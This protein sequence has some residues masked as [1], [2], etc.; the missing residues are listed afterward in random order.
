MPAGMRTA[1]RRRRLHPIV[2]I[3][4]DASVLWAPRVANGALAFD[5]IARIPLQG[6]PADLARDGHAAIAALPRANGG[7]TSETRVVIALPAG[8]V[9]RK[10]VVL[11]AAVEENLH[12]TLALRPRP[13]HAVQGGRSVFRRDR[14]GTRRG[15]QG[16]SRRACGGA[17]EFCR[18]GAKARR[19]LGRPGRC[20]HAR[21]PVGRRGARGEHAE[22]APAR[23]APRDVAMAPVADVGSARGHRPDR[24]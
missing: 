18:S 23:R 11:P 20:R 3:E 4:R 1:L 13:A 2:A 15:A 8:Q 10:S 21:I 24:R 6:D 22:P 12:Q 16:D 19:I 5:A 9:L 14:R 17:Q 7:T